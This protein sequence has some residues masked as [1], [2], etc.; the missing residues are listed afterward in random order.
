MKK[1]TEALTNTVG[2]GIMD[3]FRYADIMEELRGV[4]SKAEDIYDDLERTR[5][6]EFR[7]EKMQ[8]MPD[9]CTPL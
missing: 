1:N 3:M 8:I 6:E 4:P 2:R 9:Y 5:L 7:A